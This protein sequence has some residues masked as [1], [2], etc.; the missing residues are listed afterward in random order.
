MGLVILLQA[1]LVFSHAVDSS[2]LVPVEFEFTRVLQSPEIGVGLN[3]SFNNRGGNNNKHPIPMTN[4]GDDLWKVT[5]L[6][7]PGV[8]PYKFVTFRAG[9]ANDTIISSWITD[10]NNPQLDETSYNNSVLRV[11]DP[12]IY[13]LFPMNG[14]TIN[15]RTPEISAGRSQ[16]VCISIC[17]SQRT[18]SKPKK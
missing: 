3:G 1:P 15:N 16:V 5:V 14:S 10:P 17:Y 2:R 11:S 7:G 13:Y 18:S 4:V 8:W 6:L 9:S 12:M